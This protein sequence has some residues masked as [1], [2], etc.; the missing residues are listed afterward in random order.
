MITLFMMGYN[1]E[2]FLQYAI[3]HYRKRFP[4]CPIVFY[5]NISTDSTAEIAKKNGAQVIPWDTNNVIDDMKM[6]DL[7]N[8]CWKNATTDWVCVVDP[9]ELI[10]I[11]EEQLKIEA[12]KGTTII[13]THGLNMVNMEDNYDFD[14]I[15]HATEVPQYSKWALFNRTVFT[16]INYTCG[17]H[18]ASPQ[19]ADKIKLS[20][21]AYPLWHF[22]CINPDY[23]V[24]RAKWTASRISE[25]NKRNGLGLYWINTDEGT[26]AGFLVGRELAKN[27][28]VR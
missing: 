18:S 16:N 26:R 24:L 21:T 27:N 25:V 23:L 13:K 19:P 6:R 17:A 28:K 15:C 1:E 8:N 14:N 11:N 9:D 3:D 5:D 2:V 20:D 7:K 22:K 4:N 12:S 10:N